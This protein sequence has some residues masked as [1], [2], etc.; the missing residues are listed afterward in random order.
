MTPYQMLLDS[1]LCWTSVIQRDRLQ[2]GR[3]Y[4]GVLTTGVYCRPSCPSRMPK[5]ANVR[6]YDTRQAAEAD[7]LRPCLRC[8]PGESASA[9]PE[10]VA[11]VCRHIEA[12]CTETLP[13]HE[14]NRLSG[15]SAFHMQ[16]SF[17]AVT[18]VTPRQYQ[19]ACRMKILR[20]QLRSEPSVTNAIF[21]AGY[22]SLSRVYERSD[23]ELGMTPT[24][25]RDGGLGL[26]ITWATMNTSLGL[27]LLAATDR[28]LCFLQFGESERALVAALRADFP[29]A[30]I[31]PL[32]QPYP[33]QFHDWME[34]VEAHL[35]GAAAARA[36]AEAARALPLDIRASAFQC[37]V[38]NYL[39]TIPAG[40]TQSYQQVAQALGRPSAA[41]A[42]ARACATNR[43]A[44]LIPCH[45]VL[46]GD[47]ELGGY[48]W[49]M[50]RKQALLDR[51]RSMAA[52]QPL[53]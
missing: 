31:T 24:Q 22:G 47:G 18:G 16:R 30:V 14:L 36:G 45:R 32:A 28:G 3:F 29:N 17:K 35:S 52:A 21:D 27:M 37:L 42:V 50:E 7:G 33:Q 19:Q 13:L 51:E 34:G 26:S 10:W 53:H 46:R 11:R 23:S 49:G 20:R 4:Y 39:R 12:N 15:L 40:S 9:Q 6:F 48:R 44:L 1:E 41:R 2:D 8:K 43:V 5:R 38:W 25:Y